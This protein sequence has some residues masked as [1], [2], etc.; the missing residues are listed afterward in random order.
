MAKA[1]VTRPENINKIWVF[2]V[3]SIDTEKVVFHDGSTRKSHKNGV[4]FWMTETE[5]MAALEFAK[6]VADNFICGL[7]R[8]ARHMLEILDE[9]IAIEEKN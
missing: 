1:Y 7:R 9:D 2:D 4:H 3:E 6:L 5:A 8:E